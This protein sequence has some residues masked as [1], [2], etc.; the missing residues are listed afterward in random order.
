MPRSK[1]KTLTFIMTGMLSASLLVSCGS[2]DNTP[3]SLATAFRYM[4]NSR[5]YTVDYVGTLYVAHT[6]IYTENSVG[7]YSNAYKN[8][9]DYYIKDSGGIYHLTYDD[10]Y[11]ASEYLS[12]SDELFDYHPSFYHLA[13]SFVYSI[14]SDAK[15][16]TITDKAYRMGFLTVVGFSASD[17]LHLGTLTASYD[18]NE[19]TFTTT[20]NDNP[21]KFVAKN[22]GTTVNKEVDSFLASGGTHFSPDSN[23]SKMRT[24]IRDNNF[25][26]GIYQLGESEESTGFIGYSYFHPHYFYD[27]YNSS[28][29]SF[30]GAMA[31]NCSETLEHKA[32]KGV[33]YFTMQYETTE[34]GVVANFQ[35]TEMPIHS[36]PDIVTCYH[37]PTFLALLDNLQ[38][39][40]E[41]DSSYFPGISITGKGYMITKATLMNDFASNFN[42]DSSF[43]GSTPIAIGIDFINSKKTE[44]IIVYF[45]YVFRNSNENYIFHV[46][47][48]RFGKAGNSALDQAYDKFNN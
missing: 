46:P 36:E 24:L 34:G 47:L 44:D 11:Y 28:P 7:V 16:V 5:N 31:F 33:Y 6:L 41:W 43:P 3:T 2:E 26:Q 23:L 30:N 35:H 21:L 45:Y 17:V 29:N 9:N 15:S 1:L 18:N 8:L 32:Y 12:G 39:C 25:L 22:F 14:K 27:I 48:L 10:K 42:L 19:V 20:L 40:K 13:Q 38:F 37:Y 4:Y